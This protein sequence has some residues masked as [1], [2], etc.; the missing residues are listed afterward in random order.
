MSNPMLVTHAF[1]N[2]TEGE[3]WTSTWCEYCVHDHGMHDD[4]H[5][6]LCQLVLNSMV[7]ER[8]EPINPEAWVAEPDDGQFFLPSR[9][10]CLRFTPCYSGDCTGDPGAT[11]RAERVADVTAYW[12]E[13]TCG[14]TEAT[15]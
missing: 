11:E 6:P 12:R 2:G 14:Q 8:G 1:S 9:M 7:A 15:S 5:D 13:R 4:S 10:I 3:A